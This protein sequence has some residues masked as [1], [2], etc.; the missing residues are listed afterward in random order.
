MPVFDVAAEVESLDKDRLGL[1]DLHW[2]LDPGWV[3]E[4]LFQAG[5][6]PHSDLFVRYEGAHG[7][8]TA[9]ALLVPGADC[10]ALSGYQVRIVDPSVRRVLAQASFTI[11]QSQARAHIQPR[12]PLDEVPES[13]VEVVPA[14]PWP[15]RSTKIY[16]IRR[17]L[18][19]ADAA[20]RAERAPAALAPA[21]A[22]GDWAALAAV[23]WERC[24]RD[25]A[26][27]GDA[28]RA[29]AARRRAAIASRTCDPRAPSVVAAEVPCQSLIDGPAYLA[30]T[31]GS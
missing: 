14:N 26:A 24:R 21:S 5:L 9:E 12:F 8:V 23:A 3:R 16:R 13:W 6:S 27:A 22:R 19:W 2:I 29:Q 15:V 11:A 4:G 18:R 20:L 31:L 17:A 10:D 7:R 28:D 1:I 30:E 25:W